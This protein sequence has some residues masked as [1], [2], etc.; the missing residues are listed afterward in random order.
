MGAKE[1]PSD[2]PNETGRLL[3]RTGYSTDRWGSHFNFIHIPRRIISSRPV[4]TFEQ[5]VSELLEQ[6][7]RKNQ[8]NPFSTEPPIEPEK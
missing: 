2:G 3:I 8:L 4:K 7:Q 1:K 6:V 5:A